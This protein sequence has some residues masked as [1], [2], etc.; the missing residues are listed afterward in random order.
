MVIAYLAALRTSRVTRS[1]QEPAKL[2]LAARATAQSAAS[3]PAVIGVRFALDRGHQRRA[4]PVRSSLVGAAF[5]ALVVVAV[6][7]F[8]ASL[9]HLVSTPAESGWTWDYIAFDSSARTNGGGDCDPVT[10]KVTEIPGITDVGAICN[11]SVEVDGRPVTAWGF[12]NVR[13]TI[14]PAVVEGR[15]PRAD[16]EVTLGADTLAAVHRSIGD[17][18]RIGGNKDSRRFRIVG[19]SA[20][21]GF[22]DPQPLA[23][24]AAF[25]APALARLGVSGGWNVIV[26]VGAHADRASLVK[27]I[28][29][30]PGPLGGGDQ[31]AFVLP[32]EVDRVQQIHG[33][34]VTLA[35]FVAA[36][37]LVAVG[38]GLVASVRR[39]RRELGVLKTLGFTR[40]QVRA[41]VAWQASTV[42]LVGL[43][44]GLPLGLIVGRYAWRAVVDELGVASDPTWPVVGILLFVP[45]AMLSVNLVAAIPARRAAGARPAVVLRSE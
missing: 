32:A 31:V 20:F 19:Q 5:G 25:T 23:D 29:P 27:K 4:L 1:A 36:V 35:A 34:P 10:T 11:G 2:G 24:G 38:L 45:L 42:A 37:A 16:D 7:V 9:H 30:P 14:D 21:P 28:A 12:S 39:H 43:V 18:V 6:M 33:L 26:R 3:P 15:A 40:R 44:V 17:V 22:A 13:G 41:T 8:A